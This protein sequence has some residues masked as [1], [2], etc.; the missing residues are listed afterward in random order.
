MIAKIKKINNK[1]GVEFTGTLI[2]G[3]VCL[4][5]AIGTLLIGHRS[6]NLNLF[7]LIYI[8]CGVYAIESFLKCY[9]KL[10]ENKI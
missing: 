1:Y 2:L 5:I 8:I 4:L 3:I 7:T 9:K 10:E 6:I